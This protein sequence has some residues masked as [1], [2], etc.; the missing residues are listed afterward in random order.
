MRRSLALCAVPAL[1]ACASAG[2]GPGPDDR[3]QVVTVAS[4]TSEK[5]FV[6]E[7][8]FAS[9]ELSAH[10]ALVSSS[11][12]LHVHERHAET[13][14]VIAGEGRMTVGEQ[15]IPIGPGVLVHVPRGVAHAVEARS[16]LTALS[17]FTPPFDGEDRRFLE[18]D[19][20]R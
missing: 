17:I 12:P 2:S 14:L 15:E 7:L 20:A 16:P 19:A 5:P 13:V 3:P 6:S 18:P 11:M 10:R 8:L 9:S 4:G 1:A